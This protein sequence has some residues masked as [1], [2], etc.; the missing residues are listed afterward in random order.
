MEHA[1]MIGMI[2][3]GNLGTALANVIATNGYRVLGW[4]YQAA[5]VSAINTKHENPQFL[6]GVLLDS[7]L[8]AT[9]RLVDVVEHCG[10]IFVALPSRYIHATL[11]P[12]RD[13]VPP[14]SVLVNTAKGIDR[15]T[16]LTAAQT[17]AA[18]FPANGRVMLSG[19]SIANEFARGLPTVVMLAGRPT[20]MLFGIARLL[21]NTHFRVRFSDD[22]IGVELG[23]VLKNAYVIGLGLFDG[24]QIASVN[25][26]SVYL[27]LALEEMTRIGVALGGRA[28]TFA[29][30]AGMGDL[31]ATALSDASH[32]RRMGQLLADDRSIGEIE[33]IMGVLPEGYNTI[34]TILFVAEKLHVP[35][36][37]AKALWDVIGGRT[38]AQHFID[39]FIKDFVA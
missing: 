36:P 35:A 1:Q 38:T 33:H 22:E 21:D 26:R 30:L 9:N 12:L 15:N 29:Y 34:Q 10:T 31:L 11:A 32:N 37:L 8:H 14:S 27:T 4:E 24:K 16:G 18:L 23:G 39:A 28:D 3:L 7:K 25:F 17:L 19:P 13:Q 6:P 5:V 2:G 20:G